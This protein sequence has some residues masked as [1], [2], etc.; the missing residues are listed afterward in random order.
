MN[1]VSSREGTLSVC[2]VDSPL[3]GSGGKEASTQDYNPPWS[4]LISYVHLILLRQIFNCCSFTKLMV[5]HVIQTMKP[6]LMGRCNHHHRG[7]AFFATQGD[8]K[9][10]SQRLAIAMQGMQRIGSP[11][12]FLHSRKT[13]GFQVAIINF[14][15]R[16][17]GLVVITFVNCYWVESL[18]CAVGW[19]FWFRPCV[20]SSWVFALVKSYYSLVAVTWDNCCWVE[21]PLTGAVWF[22]STVL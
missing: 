1:F 2:H 13:E 4:R 11:K 12:G 9:L 18:T 16:E 21:E 10:P 3:L 20:F 8:F 19:Y 15:T 22:D 14:C 5:F 17:N 6:I 7:F